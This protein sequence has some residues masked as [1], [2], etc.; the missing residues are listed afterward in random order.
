MKE[1]LQKVQAVMQDFIGHTN[2]MKQGEIVSPYEINVVGREM[3][4]VHWEIAQEKGRM[5]NAKEK[6]H[7]DRKVSTTKFFMDER[8]KEECKSAKDAEVSATALSADKLYEEVDKL[9]DYE[10][11]KE[12]QRSLDRA[13]EQNR[14]T[15]SLM[16]LHEKEAQ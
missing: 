6:A 14:S 4:A 10:T 1:L 12:I 3:I 15:L 16:K 7:I 9:S 8:V 5:F 2:R 11:M 13:I